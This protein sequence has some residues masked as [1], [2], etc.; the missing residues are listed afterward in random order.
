MNIYPVTVQQLEN[1]SQGCQHSW[2]LLE[3][4]QSWYLE[5]VDKS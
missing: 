1:Q 2:F 4:L 5:T 3:A